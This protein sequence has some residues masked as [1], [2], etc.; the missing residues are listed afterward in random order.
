MGQEGTLLP[1]RPSEDGVDGF[2][3]GGLD[4]LPAGRPAPTAP[5]RVRG[6][7]EEG[8]E[9]PEA[10]GPSY[11]Q[12]VQGQ[13]DVA[14]EAVSRAEARRTGQG[15]LG[16]LSRF[17]QELGAAQ[18]QGP[19]QQVLFGNAPRTLEI[20]GRQVG[21]I[22][23]RL[24]GQDLLVPETDIDLTGR[25]STTTASPQGEPAVDPT[26]RMLRGTIEDRLAKAYRERDLTVEEEDALNLGVAGQTGPA[27]AKKTVAGLNRTLGFRHPGWRAKDY[28]TRP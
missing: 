13:R 15:P 12:Q 7:L 18:G 6:P 10:G 4:G 19:A 21:A 14:D 26:T 8:A 28:D 5:A 3:P 17:G 24:G 27:G 25:R 2:S 11:A 9:L 20:E 16:F 22:P 1:E 23:Q